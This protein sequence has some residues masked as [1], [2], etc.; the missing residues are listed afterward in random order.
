MDKYV[1]VDDG[2]VE[3]RLSPH[4]V[5]RVGKDTYLK[6]DELEALL[7]AN[8]LERGAKKIMTPKWQDNDNV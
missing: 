2:R 8:T 3:I 5:F 1:V 7:L 6:V 4:N